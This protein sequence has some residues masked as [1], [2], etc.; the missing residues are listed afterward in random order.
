MFTYRNILEPTIRVLL[1]VV[2]THAT[3]FTNS[4]IATHNILFFGMRSLDLFSILFYTP[5]RLEVISLHLCLLSKFIIISRYELQKIYY[6]V[7]LIDILSVSSSSTVLNLSL[8]FLTLSSAYRFR[9]ASLIFIFDPF[10][11]LS[12]I[13]VFLAI[14]VITTI[15]CSFSFLT[16]CQNVNYISNALVFRF[17]YF[18]DWFFPLVLSNNHI[19]SILLF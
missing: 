4:N 18:F 15:S 14:I 17:I 1:M 5:M 2:Y 8:T 3:S 19:L 12:L 11:Y 13:L 9:T 7:L 16:P 10:L 6:L